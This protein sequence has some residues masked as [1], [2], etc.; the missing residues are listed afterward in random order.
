MKMFAKYLSTDG[1]FVET[2]EL[3]TDDN[4]NAICFLILGRLVLLGSP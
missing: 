2:I 1:Y 4:D 3:V